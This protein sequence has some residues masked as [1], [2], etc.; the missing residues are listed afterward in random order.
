MS[1]R[2]TKEEI[3]EYLRYHFEKNER[4]Q[5]V[6]KSKWIIQQ[7]QKDLSDCLPWLRELRLFLNGADGADEIDE[8][9]KRIK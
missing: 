5:A 4:H 1:E 6:G 7:Q 3:T 8:L 2:Y 9:I